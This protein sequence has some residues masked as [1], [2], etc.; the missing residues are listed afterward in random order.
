MPRHG[1]RRKGIR[2]SK[3]LD[4]EDSVLSIATKS[5]ELIT[6]S[7]STKASEVLSIMLNKGIRSVPVAEKATGR[8]LGIINTTDMLDFLGAGPRNR[9]YQKSRSRELDAPVSSIMEKDVHTLDM[10]ASIGLALRT[11]RKWGVGALPITDKG[12]LA[13]IITERDILDRIK[14]RI[15]I[16]VEDVMRRKPFFVREEYPIYDV[17][18]ILVHGP[19]RRLPV[20]KDGILTGIVTPHDILKYLNRGKK[21]RWLKR[22]RVQIRKAMNENA[23]FC[24]NYQKLHDAVSIMHRR[25]VGGLPVVRGN[26]MDIVGIITE[27]DVIDLLE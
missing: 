4:P 25:R 22:E 19:Y 16:R 13:G 10:R 24:K 27:K 7:G 15:G 9:V 18:K 12:R 5:G 23:I 26:E 14:G 17:A 21:L 11:M 3:F 1:K 8:L 2:L 6:V 20:V